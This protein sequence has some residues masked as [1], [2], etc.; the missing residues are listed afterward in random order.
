MTSA[1]N[2][3]ALVE[4]IEDQQVVVAI[5]EST[6]EMLAALQLAERELAIDPSEKNLSKLRCIHAMLNEA[7]GPDLLLRNRRH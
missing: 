3:I 7:G 2:R 5:Y 4:K 6:E 1:K